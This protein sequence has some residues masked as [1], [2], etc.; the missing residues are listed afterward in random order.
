MQDYITMK[1]L[2]G[3][4]LACECRVYCLRRAGSPGAGS[5]RGKKEGEVAS[6]LPLSVPVTSLLTGYEFI[7]APSAAL[8]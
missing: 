2:S 3:R 1:W 6:L 4:F 8:L 7:K 5:L